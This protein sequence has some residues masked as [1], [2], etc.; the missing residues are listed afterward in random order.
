MPRL[1]V[2][3]LIDHLDALLDQL[4]VLWCNTSNY[5]NL[6]L[7]EQMSQNIERLIETLKIL[8]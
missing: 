1:R 4:S 6:A 5:E 8:S 7:I 2:H 3:V